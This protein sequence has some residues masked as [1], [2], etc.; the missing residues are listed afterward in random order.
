MKGEEKS[1]EGGTGR[2]RGQGLDRG[3]GSGRGGIARVQGTERSGWRDDTVIGDQIW[4]GDVERTRD[5]GHDIVL[6]RAA[7]E[8][9][10][11]K[12]ASSRG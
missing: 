2:G 1:I 3:P 8:L 5:E 4:T 11:D 7:R 10:E 9:D 6:V 12:S